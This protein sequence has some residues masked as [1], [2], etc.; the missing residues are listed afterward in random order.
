MA[1][2]VMVLDMRELG[3]ILECW[4]IPVKMS[5]PFMDVWV[6]RSDISDVGLEML[7][8]NNIKSHNG[9]VQPDIRLRNL[10]SIVK[11]PFRLRKMPLDSIKTVEKRSHSFLICVLRGGEAGL[12]DAV[13][14]VIVGPFVCSF[15]FGLKISREEV[16]VLVFL[17]E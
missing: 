4:D 8:I 5:K 15:D 12:V 17:L 2:S 11:R 13:V 10:L 16:D 1:L 14:D 3:C 9:C 7:Y 6:A